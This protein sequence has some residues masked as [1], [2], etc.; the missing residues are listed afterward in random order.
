MNVVRTSSSPAIRPSA[1]ASRF[2][3]SLP[4]QHPAHL[5]AEDQPVCT[6]H[7]TD[8]TQQRRQVTY[9]PQSAR[10]VPSKQMVGRSTLRLFQPIK[11]GAS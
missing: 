4:C 9:M 7:S 10:T 2:V 8:M 1:C 3:I 6:P 11:L 5:H